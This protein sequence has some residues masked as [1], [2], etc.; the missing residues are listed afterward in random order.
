MTVEYH[1]RYSAMGIERPNEKSCKGPCEATGVVPVKNRAMT[2][3]FRTDSPLLLNDAAV[4]LVAQINFRDMTAEH[5]IDPEYADDWHEAHREAHSLRYVPKKMIT[6]WNWGP[7]AKKA[8]RRP[9]Q[10]HKHLREIFKYWRWLWF[11]EDRRE[12][13]G[14][15]FI[16]C[17]T[18]NGTRLQPT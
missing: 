1:D 17:H 8:L 18:C 6:G 7:A 11:S 9:W 13:D 4:D 16:V 5:D 12:C 2:K 14:W 15:H 3:L 10:T